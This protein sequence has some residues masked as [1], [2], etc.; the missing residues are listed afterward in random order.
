MPTVYV[1]YLAFPGSTNLDTL[2]QMRYIPTVG[3]PSTP[4]LSYIGAYNYVHHARTIIQEG[5]EKVSSPPL[6]LMSL[7]W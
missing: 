7:D 6:D 4:L 1:V 3:D 5:Y 2:V